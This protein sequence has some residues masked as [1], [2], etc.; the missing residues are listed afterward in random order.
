MPT[1]R[2]PEYAVEF[3]ITYDG[4]MNGSVNDHRLVYLAGKAECM[5]FVTSLDRFSVSNVQIWRSDSQW[6]DITMETAALDTR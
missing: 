4:Q 3:D 1:N 6:S 5:K 2:P